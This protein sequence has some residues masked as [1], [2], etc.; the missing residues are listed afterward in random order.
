MAYKIQLN[1]RTTITTGITA[2]DLSLTLTSAVFANFTSDY[3]VIDYDNPTKLEVIKC[4]VT[5]TTVTISNRGQEGTSAQSHDAGAKIAY[6]FVPSH[7]SDLVTLATTSEVDGWQ[8]PA[9]TWTY[10][11]AATITVPSGAASIYSV[12]DK[13]KY[14]NSIPLT[15]YWNMDGNSTDTKGSNNG[16]DTDISYTATGTKF[17]EHAIFN[18]TSSKIEIADHADLKPTGAFTIGCWIKTSTTAKTIFQSYSDNTN[19]NGIQM[20][21]VSNVIYF[22]FGNNAA[23][24]ASTITGS[25]SVVDG[26]WH[27]IVVSSNGNLTK[28]FVDGALDGSGYSVTPS[29]AATN[30]VRIG[31]NNETGSDSNFFNGSIDDVFLINGHAVDEAWV[32]A[33][34]AEATAQGTADITATKYFYVTNVA[35]TVLT[36]NGGADYLLDN[37]T[38]TSNYYSKVSSPVGFPT[39]GFNLT[40]N[41]GTQ[42]LS[43]NGRTATIRGKITNTD[44]TTNHSNGWYA[45]LLQSVTFGIPFSTLP[46]ASVSAV[47]DHAVGSLTILSTTVIAMKARAVSSIAAGTDLYWTAIGK[48]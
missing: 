34:Y 1:K 6:V 18:G 4:A 14:N 27:Y 19:S 3:L 23:A 38:I 21:I 5:G 45:T 10:A 28:I 46:V 39:E 11:S 33:K 31:C 8:D 17:V 32:A 12:G 2:S 36:L 26:N 29:Y 37:R 40:S 43:M 48:I 41:L 15:S 47:S 13:I 24:A 9:Q 30:Y 22:Y 42:V 25:T 16:T 20:S 7:Y 35:D 44:N